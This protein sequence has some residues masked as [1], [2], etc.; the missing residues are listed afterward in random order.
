MASIKSLTDAVNT[1]LQA[2]KTTP[3]STTKIL[4]TFTKSPVPLIYE[5]GLPQLAP[6][7]GRRFT[8]PE[9]VVHYFELLGETL[10]IEE[11]KFE[12]EGDW[13]VDGSSSAVVLR[14]KGRFCWK[15]T[16]QVWDE[17]F[18]YRVGLAVEGDGDGEMKVC[19]YRVWADTGAAYLARRGRLDEAVYDG[20]GDEDGDI[21]S[22]GKGRSQ[23]VL[24]NG[25]NVYGSCG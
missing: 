13:V 2:L 1:F 3:L 20:Y 8:G 4:Q 23:D 21:D 24:G 7:L 10:S 16:G 12:N 5:H 18:I 9:G 15:G 11:M 6:F 19:E 25:L 14:G 22:N 17:T